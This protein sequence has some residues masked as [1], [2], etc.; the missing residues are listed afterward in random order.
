MRA[1]F[2]AYGEAYGTA[3]DHVLAGDGVSVAAVRL[4]GS[5]E[6]LRAAERISDHRPVHARLEWG[7]PA[8]Q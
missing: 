5:A 2:D 4:G 7:R 6:G 8:E 1:V 3:C